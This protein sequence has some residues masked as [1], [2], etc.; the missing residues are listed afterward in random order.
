MALTCSGRFFITCA[1]WSLWA[2]S[3]STW[4]LRGQHQ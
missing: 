1:K 4:T 3:N 2:F